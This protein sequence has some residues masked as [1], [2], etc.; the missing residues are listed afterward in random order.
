MSIDE[1]NRILKPISGLQSIGIG[2]PLYLI[3]LAKRINNAQK[4]IM[5]MT[6]AELMSIHRSAE[7]DYLN[8]F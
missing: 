6:V 3:S 4:P 2:E 7:D 1:I 5:E 8:R